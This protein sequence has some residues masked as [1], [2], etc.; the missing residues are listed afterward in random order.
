MNRCTVARITLRLA[1]ATILTLP[2][3]VSTVFTQTFKAQ[4]LGAATSTSPGIGSCGTSSGNSTTIFNSCSSSLGQSPTWSGSAFASIAGGALRTSASASADASGLSF[5]GQLATTANAA[6]QDR[7]TFSGL[8]QPSVVSISVFFGFS[9]TTQHTGTGTASAGAQVFVSAPFDD[10][11][12][13]QISILDRWN[14]GQSVQT[15]N[16]TQEA[17]AA[18]SW[19][20]TLLRYNY[21]GLIAQPYFDLTMSL[22]STATVGGNGVC[23]D[24]SSSSDFSHTMYVAGIQAFDINGNDISSQLQLSSL[25]GVNYALGAPTTTVPEPSTFA[26]VGSALVVIAWQRRRRSSALRRA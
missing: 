16:L 7:L 12:P 11:V 4:T 2:I 25:S 17:T 9:G 20:P 24:G 18:G 10:L 3:P 22:T 26:L 5:L 23:L 6:Y 21:L 1:I 13:G 14:F 19:F 8:S 15:S